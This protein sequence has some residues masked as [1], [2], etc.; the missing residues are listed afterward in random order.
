MK[1][2]ELTPD[3]Y[4]GLDF[5]N[6]TSIA[7]GVFSGLTS[8]SQ[9]FDVLSRSRSL[10]QLTTLLNRVN[11]VVHKYADFGT[12]LNN[13]SNLGKNSITNIA[14]GSFLGLTALQYLF[15]HIHVIT[16]RMCVNQPTDTNKKTLK[17]IYLPRWL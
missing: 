7:T 15:D 10:L 14:T 1:N 9:L 2:I 16:S 17:Y 11:Y 3:I 13:C 8:L 6:I 5:Q 12:N 4:R